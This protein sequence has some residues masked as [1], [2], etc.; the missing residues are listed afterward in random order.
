MQVASRAAL[1]VSAVQQSAQPR[2][3]SFIVLQKKKKKKRQP[4]EPEYSPAVS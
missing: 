2:M 3:I 1:F 4:R